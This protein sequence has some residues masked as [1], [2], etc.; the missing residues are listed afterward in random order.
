MNRRKKRS[1]YQDLWCNRECF[2]D[3]IELRERERVGRAILNTGQNAC[4]KTEMCN[5]GRCNCHAF[6]P[7]CRFFSFYLKSYYFTINTD[8]ILSP[9][10][11]YCILS[12][13]P[14]QKVRTSCILYCMPAKNVR[15]YCIPSS[16]RDFCTSFCPAFVKQP[17]QF[18]QVYLPILKS[19]LA[20]F[21]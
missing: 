11:P 4:Q 20:Y 2:Y 6:R 19:F 5:R 21:H 1:G 15:L 13:I 10:P 16:V 17:E 14:A 18:Q 8:L 3:K 12:F 7:A 9:A